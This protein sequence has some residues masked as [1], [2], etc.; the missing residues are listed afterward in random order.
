[1]LAEIWGT[2]IFHLGLIKL[3]SLKARDYV[4]ASSIPRPVLHLNVESH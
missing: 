1:M 2:G 3:N 4:W